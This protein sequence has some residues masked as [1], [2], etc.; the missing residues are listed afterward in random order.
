MTI[1]QSRLYPYFEWAKT[2][3]VGQKISVHFF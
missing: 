1:L 2:E 3:L